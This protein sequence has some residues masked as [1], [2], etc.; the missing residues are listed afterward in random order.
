MPRSTVLLLINP[1][2]RRGSAFQPA[3]LDFFRA[4]DIDA[5]LPDQDGDPDLTD[6][7]RRLAGRLDAVV[8]GGGDGSVHAALP[9]LLDTGLPLLVIPLGTGNDL[10]RGL[11]LPSEP[12]EAA[13]LLLTGGR[14][15]IDLGRANEVLFVNVANMGLSVEVTRAL[16]GD[17]KRRFGILAYPIAAWRALSRLRPFRVRI[18]LSGETIDVRSLQLAVGAGRHY[19]G[20]MVI[21]EDA[22]IDDGRLWLYSI[23]P[24]SFWHLVRNAF[25]WRAG[26]HRAAE[27]TTARSAPWFEI[28]TRRRRTVTADG[29][30][31]TR[32]PVRFEV[33][34]RVL[35]VIVPA[36]SGTATDFVS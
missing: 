10:A 3:V 15:K 1:H 33:L 30:T 31:V 24:R 2:S 25:A 35:E 27:R 16:D 29:E 11:E 4:N 12:L 8:V 19:G 6:L 17:L 7:M 21:H 5:I 9:G 32:T 36:T 22:R 14:R 34:P 23:A 26:R 28:S 20:G 18:R 13:A